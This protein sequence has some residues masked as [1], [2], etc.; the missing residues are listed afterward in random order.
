MAVG[1][2]S[3]AFVGTDISFVTGMDT[4]VP[5]DSNWMRPVLGVEAGISDLQGMVT[6]GA[7]TSVGFMACQNVQNFTLRPGKNWVD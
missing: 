3:G 1:G 4:G 6:A 2:A 7:A 5:V